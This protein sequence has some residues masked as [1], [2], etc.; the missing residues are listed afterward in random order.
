MW[1]YLFLTFYVIEITFQYSINSH[2]LFYSCFDSDENDNDQ[3]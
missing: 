3:E 1:E 2:Y